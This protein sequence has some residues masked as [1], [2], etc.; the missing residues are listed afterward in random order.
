MRKK[1]Q[2]T[3]YQY[4]PE[5]EKLKLEDLR[6]SRDMSIDELVDTALSCDDRLIS[7]FEK[8]AD[9]AGVPVLLRRLLLRWKDMP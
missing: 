4:I 7:F 5:G 3:W 1:L 6:L 8:M 2:G 9:A